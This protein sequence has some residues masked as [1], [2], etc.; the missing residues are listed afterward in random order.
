MSDASPSAT[1]PLDERALDEALARVESAR[2]WSPR[3]LSKLEAM[4]RSGSDADLFR[5]NPIAYAAAQRVRNRL[6]LTL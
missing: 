6:F 2:R 5:V 1:A 3:V 4:I